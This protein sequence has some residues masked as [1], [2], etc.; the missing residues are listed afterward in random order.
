MTLSELPEGFE[1]CPH[2]EGCK[3]VLWEG[4]YQ[5]GCSCCHGSGMID[6][7]TFAMS[8]SRPHRE[9]PLRH[10]EQMKKRSEFRKKMKERIK[11]DKSKSKR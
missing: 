2:C 9:Y 5:I 4:K 3:T 6:W 8:K 7:I 1:I 11:N 10:L